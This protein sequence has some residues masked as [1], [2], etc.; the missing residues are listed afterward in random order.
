V[1]LKSII[2]DSISKD[3][4]PSSSRIFAYVMMAQIIISNLVFLGIEITNAVS[5]FKNKGTYTPSAQAVGIF[6]MLLTHQLALLG[7]YKYHENKFDTSGNKPDDS[8]E[9]K[10]IDSV[11]DSAS[12]G[13]TDTNAKATI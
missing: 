1:S 5:E 2:L 11:V 4:K 6:G 3:G 13:N 12:S 9:I 7:I 8:K 10:Q